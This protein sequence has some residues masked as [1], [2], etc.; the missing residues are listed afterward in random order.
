[1]KDAK[2][3]FF[4]AFIFTMIFIGWLFYKTIIAYKLRK[5]SKEGFGQSLT[6][7]CPN[8]LI[9][10]D[11]KIYLYN[12][13]LANVPGVNP[14]QFNNLEEYTEFLK[15]QK[16]VNINCPVL[17]LQYTNDTQGQNVFKLRNDFQDTKYGAPPVIP[18]NLKNPQNTMLY[19]A[20]HDDGEYNINS[21][22]SQ[23]PQGQYIGSNTPLDEMN[24]YQ[25]YY[26]STD[27]AMM[28]NWDNSIAEKHI[29]QG[30]YDE[31][32]VNIYVP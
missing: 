29:A 19:D 15:W 21:F 30:V 11:G 4:I 10:K 14:I 18:V 6:T 26:L 12:S 1:M 24:D 9:E 20:G 3:Y 7:R 28:D 5:C 2:V 25:R 31:N 32:N 13:R 22:P 17:Y 8:M 27:N 16:S 23:D